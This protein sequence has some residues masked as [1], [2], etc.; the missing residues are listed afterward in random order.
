MSELSWREAAEHLGIDPATGP[1]ADPRVYLVE[2]DVSEQGGTVAVVDVQTAEP[3]LVARLT[4]APTT[5]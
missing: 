1:A 5:Q 4:P 2:L 3:Y